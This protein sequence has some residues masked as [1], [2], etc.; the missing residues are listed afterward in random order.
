MIKVSLLFLSLFFAGCAH[1][2]NCVT[3]V[4]FTPYTE[5]RYPPKSI[6]DR[7]LMLA[8]ITPDRLFEEIGIIRISKS[9]GCARNG[10]YHDQYS[11]EQ[12]LIKKGREVGADAIIDVKAGAQGIETGIAIVFKGRK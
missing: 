10:A 8:S 2:S 1:Y 9:P 3:T 11:D 4:G 12:S 7:I 5:T 6:N